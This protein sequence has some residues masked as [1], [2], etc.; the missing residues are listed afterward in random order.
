MNGLS[1]ILATWLPR[2][3]QPAAIATIVRTHGSTYRKPGARMLITEDLSTV[4]MVSGGCLE[5]DIARHARQ[6]MGEGR[7]KLVP[8]DTQ[9]LF[10]CN[11]GLEV[12]IEPIAADGLGKT[13]LAASRLLQKRGEVIMVTAFESDDP[14]AS[15][16][17]TL[18]TSG[19]HPNADGGRPVLTSV[20]ASSG[21]MVTALVDRIP[22][23]RRLIIF[24]ASPDLLPLARL[25]LSLHWEVT[26]VVH[27]SQD[28]PPTTLPV[29]ILQLGPE[30]VLQS[31]IPDQQSAA[32]VMTHNYG[33]D[34]AYLAA[35]L[36]SG[37]P[38]IGL[39]GPK[40]RRDKMLGEI[41]DLFPRIA[42][43]C[44]DSLHNPAGLDIGADGP[45]EIALS[46]CAEIN[47]VFTRR[48]GG[49]L[50]ESTNEYQ[51]LPPAL[52]SLR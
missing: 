44:P 45:E 43:M 8:Y 21:V 29:S 10:G 18:A 35:L 27:P 28:A 2:R 9:K 49:F 46:I 41:F 16:G 22:P 42:P 34:L 7:A 26:V 13:L 24:G 39:L 37:L 14:E 1:A 3:D 30:T 36:S 17:T 48:K 47:A 50:T 20:Q 38:Y 25:A 12:F 52:A 23:P 31:V 15:L 5:E 40:K 51:V 33:R 11:G 19:S 4:G 6:V 32:V